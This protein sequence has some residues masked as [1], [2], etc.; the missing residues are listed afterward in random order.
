MD[1]YQHD[2]GHGGVERCKRHAIAR[3]SSQADQER[4]VHRGKRSGGGVFP[5]LPRRDGTVDESP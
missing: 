4:V 3:L 1:T 2:F 5:Q